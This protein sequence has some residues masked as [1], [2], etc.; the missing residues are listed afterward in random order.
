MDTTHGNTTACWLADGDE[1][2][3][4]MGL[5]RVFHPTNFNAKNQAKFLDTSSGRFGAYKLGSDPPPG[6]CSKRRQ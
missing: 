1:W 6:E 2:K 3:C 5:K 4:V